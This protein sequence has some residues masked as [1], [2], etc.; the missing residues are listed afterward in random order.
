[1]ALMLLGGAG[2][3]S[4]AERARESIPRVKIR[5]HIYEMQYLGA[6]FPLSK[7]LTKVFAPELRILRAE[8]SP[9]KAN[10]YTSYD[11]FVRSG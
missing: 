9:T 5:G 6:N 3:P 7:C 8:A 2:A 11:P 1:M 4:H 10:N